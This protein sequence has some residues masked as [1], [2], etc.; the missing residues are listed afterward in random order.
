MEFPKIQ[1]DKVAKIEGRSN[2]SYNYADLA[3]VIAAIDPILH[4]H[5]LIQ[6]QP[7][8]FIDGNQFI[9]TI[10]FHTSGECSS[11]LMILSVD[12][13]PR[14]TGGLISYYRRYALCAA[15]GITADDDT[16]AAPISQDKQPMKA[17]AY[18]PPKVPSNM[19]VEQAAQFIMPFGKTKGAALSKL[20][21]DEISSALNWVTNTAKDKFLDFQLAA[22]ILIDAANTPT[23]PSYLK[24]ELPF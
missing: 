6:R 17:S 5:G 2:F 1:K 10:I 12:P 22:S 11:N 3:D 18:V 15:L 20:S 9:E 14:R 21:I 13:D 8:V 23:E 24:E 16:D 4:K 7:L 19:T